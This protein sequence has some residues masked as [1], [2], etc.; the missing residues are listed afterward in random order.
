MEVTSAANVVAEHHLITDAPE[1]A[2]I[3]HRLPAKRA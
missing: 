3:G 2:S 1:F